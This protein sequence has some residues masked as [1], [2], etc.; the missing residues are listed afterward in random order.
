M[1]H[2][3]KLLDSNLS[4]SN[5]PLP[6]STLSGF[7]YY[8]ELTDFA[9]YVNFGA[10][11]GESV[12]R[13]SKR[14]KKLEVPPGEGTIQSHRMFQCVYSN[15]YH[16]RRRFPFS[17]SSASLTFESSR[18]LSDGPVMGVVPPCLP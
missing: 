11:R 15:K 7:I 17:F 8:R 13:A 4:S 12:V 1:E 10:S 3:T 18:C 5:C 2:A 14:V 16:S 6:S 9:A